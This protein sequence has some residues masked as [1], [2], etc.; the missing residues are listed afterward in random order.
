MAEINADPIKWIYFQ[1]IRNSVGE[2]HDQF[3]DDMYSTPDGR[4]VVVSRPSFRRRGLRRPRHRRTSTGASPSRVTAPTTWPV[5]RRLPG[6]GVG[7]HLN[8]VHVLD[9]STGEEL[10]S[11][12]TGDKPHE[13]IFTRDGKY[14]W[15]MSS[16]R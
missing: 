2:G 7:L 13:N 14:L 6:R 9:I 3:V 10:G 12:K 1:A 16:A 11:F 8:T 4:S 15:N 5:P